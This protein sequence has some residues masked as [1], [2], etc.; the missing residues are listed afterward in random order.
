MENLRKSS[1]EELADNLESEKDTVLSA[2]PPAADVAGEGIGEVPVD[3]TPR[4]ANGALSYDISPHS[5]LLEL[6]YRA[7]RNITP[8]DFRSV[9]SARGPKEGTDGFTPRL[10]RAW[11][12]DPERTFRFL[13]HLRDCRGGRGEKRLFRVACGWLLPRPGGPEH[14]R[15]NLENIVHYGSWKDL[16]LIFL[17]TPLEADAL[18]LFARQLRADLALCAA[19]SENSVENNTVNT[20]P[21]SLCAKYA[22]S[23]GDAFDR[24]HRAAGKLARLLGLRKEAYRRKVLRPL[25]SRLALVEQK[26]CAGKWGEIDYSQVPSQ[27]SL[28]YKEAF[29]Q[30]DGKRYL[31]YLGQVSR[32]EKKMNTG[33]LQAHQIV[34]SYLRNVSLA[35]EEPDP[36]IEALWTSYIEERKAKWPEGASVLPL[37]DT[38]GSMSGMPITVALALGLTMINVCRC[39]GFERS[40][41]N[42]S[43]RPELFTAPESSLHAQIFALVREEWG[44]NTDFQKVFEKILERH[45]LNLEKGLK[46]EIPKALLVLSDMQFDSAGGG[47]TNWEEIERKFAACGLQRPGIIFWNLNGATKDCPVSSGSVERCVLLSGYSDSM[48]QSLLSGKIP[49][50]SEEMET[51]LSKY[52]R[53]RLAGSPE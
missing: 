28:L 48:L 25:R 47:G 18:G 5:P 21:I 46:R 32:G 16:L 11:E 24:K 12:A 35:R 23:E 30:Q 40:W 20:T 6:F 3:L 38:S 15:A 36:A 26:M 52:E 13:F 37:V 39:P 22:P 34:E 14:L 31:E 9:P 29:A 2:F 50:P 53:V 43:A 8:A 19:N 4:T 10:A 33:T 17:G 7:V 51:T 41:I 42:F 49:S 1:G 44:G 27:A 45:R